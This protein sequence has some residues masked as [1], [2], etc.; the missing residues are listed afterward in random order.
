MVCG[1]RQ[2]WMYTYCVC[3]RIFSFGDLWVSLYLV[4]CY[5]QLSIPNSLASTE[6]SH[7]FH[8]VTVKFVQVPGQIYVCALHG[9]GFG[10]VFPMSEIFAWLFA[11]NVYRSVRLSLVLSS[12]LCMK[13]PHLWYCVCLPSCVP[14]SVHFCLSH[15][16][17]CLL[18]SAKPS[19]LVRR[20]RE[21]TRQRAKNPAWPGSGHA[22]RHVRE[23][24]PR[25][26]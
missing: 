5:F 11:L 8:G 6:F 13:R 18:G 26:S 16:C 7:T 19:P 23:T 1:I 14:V 22:Q 9:F 15:V 10:C 24:R 2:I 21:G 17:V 25:T 12:S 20:P 4:S 3:S